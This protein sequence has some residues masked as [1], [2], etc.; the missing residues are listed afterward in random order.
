MVPSDTSSPLRPLRYCGK[1]ILRRAS[2]GSMRVTSDHLWL[3]GSFVGRPHVPSGRL[4]PAPHPSGCASG[5]SAPGG[6]LPRASP[7]SAL[8]LGAEGRTRSGHLAAKCAHRALADVRPPAST[9]APIHPGLPPVVRDDGPRWRHLC[10]LVARDTSRPALRRPSA[11]PP[12]SP[13]LTTRDPA[14]RG[15]RPTPGGKWAAAL[16]FAA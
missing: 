9:G 2:G 13:V 8:R 4:T 1:Y 15:V 14:N 3:R 10:A 12:H 7:P 5:Q 11:A 16:W 6:A